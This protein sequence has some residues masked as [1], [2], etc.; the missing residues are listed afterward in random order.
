V[1]T[2]EITDDGVGTAD[3]T[4]GAETGG[5]CRARDPPVWAVLVP[6]RPHRPSSA[7]RRQRAQAVE[8]RLRRDADAG[9]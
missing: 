6:I 5:R 2:V 4:R 8:P 1:L 7:A 9:G 3:E